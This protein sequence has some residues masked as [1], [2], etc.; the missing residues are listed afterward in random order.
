MKAFNYS[1]SS[2]EIPKGVSI[3]SASYMEKNVDFE[4]D[5]TTQ[6]NDYCK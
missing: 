1:L 2:D 3:E 6:N 4:K 5:D